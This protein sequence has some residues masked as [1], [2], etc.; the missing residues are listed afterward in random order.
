MEKYCKACAVDND[1]WAHEK[2]LSYF[3]IREIMPWL[4]LIDRIFFLPLLCVTRYSI[5]NITAIFLRCF[6]EPSMSSEFLCFFIHLILKL[7]PS[8]CIRIKKRAK[9]GR[10][11]EERDPTKGKAGLPI[12]VNNMFLI[13]SSFIP[14]FIFFFSVSFS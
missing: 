3:A 2:C 5:L 12:N 13:I 4:S 10:R 1:T 6:N 8:F 14:N 7:E 11:V 9:P